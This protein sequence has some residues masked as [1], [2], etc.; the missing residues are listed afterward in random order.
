MS[1]AHLAKIDELR[2]LTVRA[3]GRVLKEFSRKY[4][5][6]FKGKKTLLEIGPGIG[7]LRRAW[8]NYNGEWFELNNS[9]EELQESIR[10]NGNAA[11]IQGTTNYLPFPN[12]SFDIVGGFNSFDQYL[13][14][15]H[16]V[17]ESYR[18]LKPGGLFFHMMDQGQA[19]LP[20]EMDLVKRGY[21]FVCLAQNVGDEKVL[22]GLIGEDSP[23]EIVQT[24]VVM[25]SLR[26]GPPSEI[27]DYQ[28][29]YD[30]L[31][32]ELKTKG[33]VHRNTASALHDRLKERLTEVNINEYLTEIIM[34]SLRKYFSPE[35]VNSGNITNWDIGVMTDRQK[36]YESKQYCHLG[37]PIFINYSGS[38]SI[39]R[40]PIKNLSNSFLSVLTHNPRSIEISGVDYIVAIKE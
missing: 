38:P 5:S 3:T 39:L 22:P 30:L 1:I 32:Q 9:K 21:G 12:E 18:V 34:K 6:N 11:F 23:L 25:L 15:D 20:I 28:Q 26:Y 40:N 13:D 16:I 17:N 24:S 37:M 10:R 14:L 4:R 29:E 36:L 8:P 31:F 2:D 19:T 27:S 7:Y 33:E 35:S